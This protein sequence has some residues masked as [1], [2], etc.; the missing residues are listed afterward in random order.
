MILETLGVAALLGWTPVLVKTNR[1]TVAAPDG[2]VEGTLSFDGPVTIGNNAVI[3]H[4]SVTSYAAGTLYT[5]TTSSA[6]L[7][8]G[9]TSPS[10]SLTAGTWRLFAGV[11]LAY[12]GA[13][14]TNQTCNV[15]LYNVTGSA[16]VANA[17]LTPALPP[18]TTLSYTVGMFMLPVV[19][20]VVAS[21]STISLYG[22]LSASTGAG[23]VTAG[24]GTFI[25]AQQ[26][27]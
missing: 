23:S 20:L 22:N 13:T 19:E 26:V 18:A 14:I 21:T 25:L 16:A 10:V 24:L 5:L 1:T 11:N 6:A 4:N 7:T 3:G 2:A 17:T 8:F 12:S 9:T 15:K 27:A